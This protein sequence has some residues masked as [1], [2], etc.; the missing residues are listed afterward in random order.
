MRTHS[1][2]SDR[3]TNEIENMELTIVEKRTT[4]ILSEQKKHEAIGAAAQ[5]QKGLRIVSAVDHDAVGRDTSLADSGRYGLK[6]SDNPSLRVMNDNPLLR[7]MNGAQLH[8]DMNYFS[9]PYL[10]DSAGFA[11]GV[12]RQKLS[13]G[14]ASSSSVT[15][16][17]KDEFGMSYAPMRRSI[18]AIR[19]FPDKS[20]GRLWFPVPYR[21]RTLQLSLSGTTHLL[22]NP[23]ALFS[24]NSGLKL[25]FSA[26]PALEAARSA[27]DSEKW[28]S[29]SSEGI[30]I[31][32]QVRQEVLQ[33]RGKS[34]L[35]SNYGVE[36]SELS[37]LGSHFKS[38]PSSRRRNK[39]SIS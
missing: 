21:S 33:S 34:L 3:L 12:S 23:T 32:R 7:V 38:G 39:Q 10:R 16:E 22:Q 2:E 31:E 27:D 24:S 5:L 20:S 29:D 25:A 1:H 8:V 14:I 19:I 36:Q 11:K 13:R 17:Y 18:D 35:L 15:P 4:L 26:S 37:H 28:I 6:G 9:S 30:A